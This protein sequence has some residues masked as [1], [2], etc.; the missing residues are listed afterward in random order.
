M[1]SSVDLLRPEIRQLRPYKAADYV[2]GFVRLNAN[3]TPWRPPG[4]E[5]RDGLNRYPEPRPAELTERLTTFYGLAPGQ[6]LVTRGSSE[7]IDVLIRAFCRAGQD[8]IVI[9]PPTFGMYEVYAQI[10]GAGVR[11][12]PLDRLANYSLPVDLIL[13]AWL[14]AT[15]LVFVCSPNNPTGNRIPDAEVNRLCGG[16]AGRGVVVLDAA[17]QEFAGA[18]PMHDLMARHENLV[19]LRTLSKALSLAGVRC[20]ALIAQQELVELLGRVLPPYCFPTT[21]QDAVLRSLTPEAQAELTTR[22]AL[23]IAERRRLMDALPK[24]SGINRVWPSAANFILIESADAPTLVSR[25]R[26][27]GILLRD[28]S[29]DPLLPGCVRI[30]VGSPDENDRLLEALRT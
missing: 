6:L 30:T 19:V 29:W 15:K 7:A 26:E 22:R 17:Y 24:V 5:T 12:V 14:P 9:C 23:I 4:D 8:N 25:A 21:S 20:G 11:Q 3:E 16:L 27:A 10:Q 13:G 2:G 1:S 18:D 28:F